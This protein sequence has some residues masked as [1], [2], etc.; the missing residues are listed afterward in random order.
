MDRYLNWCAENGFEFVDLEEEE[1]DA[2]SQPAL[3]DFENEKL[4]IERIVEALT[5]H[6]WGG[7]TRKPLAG[8]KLDNDDEE[9][10]LR[11]R[12]ENS[13]ELDDKDFPSVTEVKAVRDA[14]FGEHDDED[15]ME[16]AV[17][18]IKYLRDHAQNMNDTDRRR[19]AATVALSLVADDDEEFG[20]LQ[21]HGYQE[22]LDPEED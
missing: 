4:G 9:E 20:E 16:K 3:N 21:D 2:A 13:L 11:M 5:S 14:L 17:E 7:I 15:F 1:E 18:Q 6:I 19:M 12:M 10:N 22:M 8:A